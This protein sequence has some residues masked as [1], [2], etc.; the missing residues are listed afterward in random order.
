MAK[1][2][3]QNIPLRQV[4]SMIKTP[5]YGLAK[6]LDNIIK[7]CIPSQHMLSSSTEFI[8][9]VTNIDLPDNYCLVS[10]DIVS[11]F[12]N[13]PL[14][15]A[16]DLA[17]SYVYQDDSQTKPRYSIEHFKRLLQYATSGEFLYQD[18]LYRQTDGVAMGSP[19]APTLANLFLA[20]LEND[21]LKSCDAPIAYWRYVDD[22]FCVFDVSKQKPDTFLNLLNSQHDNLSFTIDVGPK[23]LPFLDIQVEFSHGSPVFSVFR[24]KS[25]T[26]LLLNFTAFCPKS[27]KVGLVKCLLSRAHRICSNWQLFNIEIEKLRG[28]FR[29]NGYPVALF[30]SITRNFLLNSLKPDNSKAQ[31]TRDDHYTFVLPYHGIISDRFKHRFLRFCRSFN[32]NAKL[33]FQPFKVSKYFSLKSYAPDLFRSCI[34]YQYTCSRDSRQSYIGKTKRHFLTRIREHGTSASAVKSHCD[35]CGCFD[36]NNFRIIHS[37]NSDYDSIICEALL[38]RKHNPTL[39]NTLSNNGQSLFLKL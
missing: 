7:P 19:L 22:I 16:I 18:K 10:F 31:D 27:W 13:V 4:V 14:T 3:K 34:I 32:V 2:H 37:C 30:D 35:N 38:I 23:A 36:Q 20:H 11:L 21:F 5:P 29:R 39:N 25:Y 1:I 9:K 8:D 33:V 28:I 24:K 12:T 6:Y 15:E 17:C 26:G